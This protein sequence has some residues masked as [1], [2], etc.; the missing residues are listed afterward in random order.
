VGE[1]IITLLAQIEDFQKRMWLKKKFV[2]GCEY[3]I[4]LDRVPEELYPEIAANEAQRK[5][6]EDQLAIDQLE[7]S[8][9]D[10][11]QQKYDSMQKLAESEQ[12]IS[13]S[14]VDTLKKLG[15]AESRLGDAARST[16]IRREI[17]VQ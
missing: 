5:V 12:A 13:S 7:I 8:R 1:K 17:G 14:R 15:E 6:Y 9:L 10:A 4:T 3:C 11:I 16:D 2:V